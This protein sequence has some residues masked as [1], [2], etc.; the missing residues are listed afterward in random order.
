MMKSLFRLLLVLGTLLLAVSLHAAEGRPRVQQLDRIVAV[1]NNDVIT[2]RELTDRMG[3]IAVQLKK[4]GTPLPPQEILAKQVLER[5]IVEKVQLQYAK[6]TGIRVDDNQVDATIQRIAQQNGV[7]VAGF[8][9][10][11][12][13]EGINFAKFREELR[14]EIIIA[15]LR[16]REVDNKITVADSEV[17]NLLAARA[18][19]SG[20]G[21]EY[22]VAH[23]LIAVPENASPEQIQESKAKAEAALAELKKG[24]NFGQV[25]ASFSDAADAMDGGQLG[26]RSP[27]RLPSVFAEA[28]GKMKSGDISPVLRSPNGFHILKLLDHRSSNAPLMVQ[29]T[30]VRHILIK[31]NE[32]VSEADAKRRLLLVR[33]R[34]VHGGDFAQLARLYSE[35]GSA[36]RG[37]DL[38]WVNPGDLVPEF[39]KAMDALKP[40]EVSEPVKSPFGWHLIQVLE[41]RTQDMSKERTKLQA[42]QEIRARKADEQY[43]DWVRQLR[44]RAF[45]EYRLEDKY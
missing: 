40:G 42:R 17:E 20:G 11:L 5:M 7:D 28:L 15:R 31:T 22:N 41:R 1:V 24:V 34:L 2:Q 18:A 43:Q 29:Q 10:T 14:N 37:G 8:R 19:L 21:D 23:I 27:A 13:K 30:H 38:G 45:V 32:A 36:S 33:D 26:W 35:D 4:Q 44:D 3:V 9:Q 12:E 25:A 39:E 6:D 16:E